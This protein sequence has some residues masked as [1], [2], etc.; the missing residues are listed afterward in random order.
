MR[1][2]STHRPLWDRLGVPRAV[3]ILGLVSLFAD[4]SS[5]MVYPL[6]PLFLT[7]TLGAP[8]LAVGLIEGVAEGTASFLKLV[9]GRASDRIGRRRPFVVWGY[10]LSATAKPLLAAAFA[11]PAV[12]GVRFVDRFGKG[13]RTAP[14]DALLAETTPPDL[15]GR[16][17]GF[18]RA[19]DTMGAVLGPLLALALVWLLDERYRIVFLIAFVPG[20]ISVY[21]MRHVA[22]PKAAATPSSP[23]GVK[24][25]ATLGGWRDLG[26]PYYALLAVT[27]LFAFGNSSD[28]FLLL[29]AKDLGLG[30]SAVVLAYVTFNVSYALLAT[31]A[32]SL[33]DRIGR[34]NV[35]VA[36][37][38]LFAA[39]YLAFGL[40]S[41]S[42]A[43]W[44][45]FPLYGLFM[46]MTE[47]VGRAYVVDFAP[48]DRH[49]TALGLY[50]AGA[51][52]AT[53]LASLTAGALWD[54]VDPAAPFVFG[55]GTALLAAALMLA[56]LPR[57]NH[58][59]TA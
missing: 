41:G 10:G 36:G 39:V 25:D 15:R 31:P 6:L 54:A 43:L 7:T 51:G 32:G 12:L 28:V 57:H 44:A 49:G 13:L 18:H 52:I 53:L 58:P 38:A 3:V 37:Y 46:A 50:H 48:P 47:G 42:A 1:E 2:S 29:R 17:F 11:W 14:R 35:I 59:R 45:L 27:L 55:G 56:V 30:A 9:S 16:A 34:R 22:E 8:A 40:A 5:E 33:S 20:A 23:A 21:L 24:G 19:M 26:R 4:V